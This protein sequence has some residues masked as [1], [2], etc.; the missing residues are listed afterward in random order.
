MPHP[1]EPSECQVPPEC[2]LGEQ[3]PGTFL[4][5]R[6][7]VLHKEPLSFRSAHSTDVGRRPGEGSSLLK[8]PF[9][10]KS[11]DLRSSILRTGATFRK[12]GMERRADTIGGQKKPLSSGLSPVLWVNSKLPSSLC[13]TFFVRPASS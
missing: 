7:S 10:P 13:K 1:E 9:E 2:S 8:P 11:L 12:N 4:H 5:P 6:S 3:R